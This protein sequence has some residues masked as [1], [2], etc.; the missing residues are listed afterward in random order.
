MQ[1]AGAALGIEL[2]STRIKAVLV[3]A[4]GA[5]LASASHAW[6][7]QLVNGV[8]T[9]DLQTVW[10]GLQGCFAKLTVQCEPPVQPAVIGI[11]GMMHGYLAFD[12]TGKQLT[13]F[14]TW[15]NTM[16]QK[17]ASELSQALQW[18]MPQRWSA[19]HYYQAILN[20][21]AH[22]GQV[23]RLTTLAGYVHG[24]LTGEYVLGVGD[25]SGMFPIN[26]K[27]LDYDEVMLQRYDA[28][29]RE[30]SQDAPSLRALL[31]RVLSA[32]Q[33]AGRLTAAGVLLL[34][35]S[36]KSPLSPA[37]PFCPPEGDAGTGMVA[38]NAVAPGTGNVSAGTSIFAMA[39]LQKPLSRA[40]KELDI[41][42]TPAGDPVAMV[43]C[44]NG[45]GDLDAWVRLLGESASLFGAS[46]PQDQLYEALLR[47]ALNGE[48]ECGGLLHCSYFS[49]EHL[50]GFAQGRP[51]FLR[52]PEASFTLPNVMRSLLFSALATLHIGMELLKQ[53]EG[54]HLE[55]MLAHGGLFKVKGVAQRFLAAAIR[56][57]VAVLQSASEGGAWGIA[58]LASFA[59]HKRRGETLQ[60]FLR[61][62]IFSQLTSTVMEPDPT[63]TVGFAEYINRYRAGLAVEQAII[64]TTIL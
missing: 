23:A 43:H 32:G 42:A 30:H 44:N 9:Y 26:T 4:Q 34:D 25:A 29:L 13:P 8:W 38:T 51:F 53:R 41:V 63:D 46:V 57:P 2:G 6:E 36:R 31:P 15:R 7:N 20:G 33:Y 27:T 5:V 61:E 17:A 35:P 54:V 52:S 49:G 21:E 14:R 18:N 40:Y 39:V 12:A 64:E 19:A 60:A 45:T 3:D 16:T 50:T 48:A 24:E 10:Q 37:I 47:A 56:T 28:V 62:R 11:S 59:L 55:Q 58:L 22:V 1:T